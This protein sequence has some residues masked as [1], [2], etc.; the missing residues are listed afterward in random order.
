MNIAVSDLSELPQERP[1]TGVL[2]L[3]ERGYL[4]DAL[5]RHG[6]RRLCAQRLR[7]E[8]AGGAGSAGGSLR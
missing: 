8:T 6:I 1:A 4:P 3:A 7:E 2:G 5:V